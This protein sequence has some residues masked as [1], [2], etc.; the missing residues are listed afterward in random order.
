MHYQISPF[1]QGKLVCVVKGKIFD[2]AVDIRK[3]SKTYGKYFSI[4]LSDKN[5]K[6]IWI[7]EGFAHGFMSLENDTIIKYKTTKFWSKNHE[8]SLLG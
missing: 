8:R 6:I 5:Q 3:N 2:V 4:I 7:P 1:E